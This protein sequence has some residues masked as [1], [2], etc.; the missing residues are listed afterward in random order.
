MHLLAVPL[1]PEI[2]LYTAHPASRLSRFAGKGG[3]PYWAYPWAGG[4]ALARHILDR[5]ETVR[6]R[7]VLDL[8]AGSGLVGIAAAK[9][10]AAEVLAAEIDRNA[11]AALDLNARANG[12]VVTTIEND[13]TP[14]PAPDVDLVLV[15]DLFYAMDLANR[16]LGFLERCSA[17]GSTVLIGDPGRE[18]LPR[19]R[20]D[21]I[22]EYAVPDVG[23]ARGAALKTGAVFSLRPA[24]P[25]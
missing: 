5:P 6:G 7:R 25:R 10:G 1:L 24:V 20:L 18:F 22:A 21:M 12:V 17:A 16:V 8:G 23:E 15:G 11:V 3:A 9:S 13:L 4:M 19:E 2:H 14:G